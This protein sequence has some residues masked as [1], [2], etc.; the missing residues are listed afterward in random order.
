MKIF[1]SWS[2]EGSI[3]AEVANLLEKWIPL[4]APFVETWNSQ[5]SIS[6]GTR[7]FNE[8]M[9]ALDNSLMCVLCLTRANLSSRWIHFEAG[10]LARTFQEQS[11]SVIP[12]LIRESI[13]G[14]DSDNHLT[15]SELNPPLN[16]FNG[17]V[18][19]KKGMKKIVNS[20]YDNFDENVGLNRKRYD[21]KDDLFLLLWPSLEEK[22]NNLNIKTD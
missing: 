19:S 8:T 7:W 16:K 14:S 6:S 3:S 15:F 13:E 4:V 11:G 18:L 20:I 17:A 5:N 1:I 9:N 2:G 22:L 21:Q 10:A 12:L